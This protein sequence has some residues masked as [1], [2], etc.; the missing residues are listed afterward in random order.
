MTQELI[1]RTLWCEPDS[2]RITLSQNELLG[3]KESLIILGE[4]GMGKSTL[5]EWISNNPDYKLCTANQLINRHDAR[6]IIGDAKVLVIDALDERM[7]KKDGDALDQV[8]RK[9][10]EI[11]Y[12][13][14]ILSCRVADWRSA[15]ATASINEQY[16]EKPLL[17]HIEPLTDVDIKEFLAKK[18]GTNFSHQVIEHFSTKGLK[19]LLGNPQTLNL[20]AKITEKD[21]LPETK[22]ELFEKEIEH[23]VKEHNDKHEIRQLDRDSALN[24]AGAAFASLILTGKDSLVRKAAANVNESELLLIEISKLAGTE[25]LETALNTR[26]FK[27]IGVDRFSYWH[28][29]IGEYLAARWLAH[30]ANTK[31]IPN[32]NVAD[33]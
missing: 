14:F 8:L 23:L 1:S 20:I 6:T 15:T 2:K 21:Q 33:C 28:R 10:G 31:R 16:D 17:L 32:E 18:L 5:L 13:R 27:G 29:S 26:L 12:P 4:A 7:A 11:S 22:R 24:C 19:D 9:L 30:Q 3:C 25:N